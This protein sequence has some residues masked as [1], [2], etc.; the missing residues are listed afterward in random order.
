PG[1][2]DLLTCLALVLMYGGGD[3]RDAWAELTQ[4]AQADGARSASVELAAGQLA[5]TFDPMLAVRHARRATELAPQTIDSWISLAKALVATGDADGA[6]EILD[7]L[8][9][10]PV[11][12]QKVLALHATASRVKIGRAS[13]RQ[14]GKSRDAAVGVP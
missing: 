10:A 2:G 3:P 8:S 7:Q 1:D 5:L 9:G 12:H 6:F 13:C 11:V 14:S 4:R